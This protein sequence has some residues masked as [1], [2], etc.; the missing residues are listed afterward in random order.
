MTG[1]EPEVRKVIESFVRERQSF[2]STDIY[3]KL[4]QHFD[5]GEN[6]I[7]SQVRAA[8]STDLMTNYLCKWVKLSLE[9]GGFMQCWKYYLPMTQVQKHPLRMRE[10]GRVEL[11]KRVLGRFS[12]LECNLGCEVKEGKITYSLSEGTEEVIIN[13]SNRLTITSKAMKNA[14]FVSGCSI[15][16][17]VYPN[18]I[19]IMKEE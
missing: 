8:Y 1:I 7:H 19:E 9:G 3:C 6:P 4:G 16:A 14:G 11:S 13:A 12:L 17:L 5:E 15:F 10:D 2:I 18:K